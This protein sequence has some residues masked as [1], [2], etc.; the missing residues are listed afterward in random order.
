M[1]K[2]ENVYIQVTPASMQAL[3]SMLGNSAAVTFS[4]D[5]LKMHA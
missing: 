4:V 3:L 5:D 1:F 2:R